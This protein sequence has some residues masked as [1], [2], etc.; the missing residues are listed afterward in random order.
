MEPAPYPPK[1]SEEIKAVI[2]FLG[3]LDIDRV[4]PE[5]KFLDKVPNLDGSVELVDDTQRPIGELKIQIKKIPDGALQFSCPIEL[6]A[7]STRVSS[8]FILVCVDIGNRKAYWC[9]I[10]AVMP[11]VRVDQKTFTIR[12]QST[13][14]EIGQGFP[15]IER[16]GSLCEDYR[17]R[18]S[19]YPTLKR[20]VDEEIGLSKLDLHD[21]HYF[22][23]FIDELNL[24]LDVDMPIVKHEYFADAWKLGVSIHE[25]NER[26]VAYSIYTIPKGENA[27]IL[28][29]IPRQFGDPKVTFEGGREIT[30]LVSFQFEGAS[31]SEVSIQW[32]LRQH[33]GDPLKEARE[34]VF[35]YMNRL[36][37]GKGLHVH[38]RNQSTELLVW[39]IRNYGHSLGLS[40]ADSYKTA[41][42]S[43]A[44]NVYL[45]A[46]YSL[47]YPRVMK[48]FREEYPE[49]LRYNPF[50]SF[51]Q[52]VRSRPEPEH[53]LESEVRKLIESRRRLPPSPI[54]TDG[55]SLQA[56]KQAV[57][58][59][60]AA[61]IT[62]IRRLDKPRSALGRGRVWQGYSGEDLKYNVLTMFNGAAEDY[63]AF[64]EGNRFGRLNSVLLSHEVAFVF[65]ADP[66]TWVDAQCPPKVKMFTVENRDRSLPLVTFIDSSQ[67]PN[68]CRKEGETVLIRGTRR[69]CKS[70]GSSLLTTLFE[71][72]PVQAV[73]YDWL[74]EDLQR[75][76]GERFGS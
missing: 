39:F 72:F 12:F 1:N 54:R 67:E 5:A 65:F 47:A 58:Y 75:R 35:R 8:P 57:D 48:H 21:R 49:M 55:F 4:K 60:T 19:E 71:N 3:L 13:I 53:P 10:S 64:V 6:V 29:H 26:S 46:W 73:V 44:L 18:I 59:L 76:F 52:I 17:N 38:G 23:Q 42:I 32:A 14:D 30:G 11:G 20:V 50:P 9:H 40:V 62:E 66:N 24:L 25:T 43:Y 37:R 31:D 45:P 7:F 74:R 69:K 56:L 16:W 22:Q 63:A 70:Y 27:P 33:F 61:E 51:E 68:E 36:L 28:T 34:F 41:Q 15:Y 2:T